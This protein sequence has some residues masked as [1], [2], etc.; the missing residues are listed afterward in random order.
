MQEMTGC[1]AFLNVLKDEGVE[2]FFGNPGT[3]ELP[4][5]DC[6]VDRP[7]LKYVLGLQEAVVSPSIR[8]AGRSSLT[9]GEWP[10]A[11]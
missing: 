4:I 7:E 8:W 3:T 11:R 10:L 2:F 6:L 9:R 1:S 5:M